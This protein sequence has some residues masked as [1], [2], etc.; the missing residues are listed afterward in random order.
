VLVCSLNARAWSA[1][2][3]CLCAFK[4]LFASSTLLISM[5]FMTPS[6][7]KS[8]AEIS[9][10]CGAIGQKNMLPAFEP[11]SFSRA[12][13]RGLTDAEAHHKTFA[14]CDTVSEAKTSLP[15]TIAADSECCF[16]EA[17]EP[18]RTKFEEPKPRRIAPPLDLR[19][20]TI[21]DE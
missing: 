21:A 18:T 11:P 13:R 10:I 4:C 1:S 19:A 2:Y 17:G 15:Y 12:L 16:V 8:H 9:S 7:D 14:V 6:K 20:C 3:M 5:N